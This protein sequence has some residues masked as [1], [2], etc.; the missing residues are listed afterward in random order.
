MG[1]LAE[2]L[3]L[4]G[5]VEPEAFRAVLD[6][7]HP[8]T[9]ERLARARSGCRSRR[10]GSSNQ[11]GLFDD[12]ALDTARTASRLRLTV[13][14]VRQL[15]L[16]GQRLDR[17][18][19]SGNYVRGSRRTRPGQKGPAA[20]VFP[21]HEFARFEAEH[22]GTK[23]RPGYDLTLRPPKSVSILWALSTTEQRAAIRQAHGEA[24]DEVVTYVERHALVARRGKGERGRIEVDGMVAAAFD[25]RT[26]RAGDPLLH[27]HVVTA[28]LTHTIDDRW[29]AIDARGL[30]DHAK[31]AGF[32]YQAHLRHLLT[33][34][35]GVA[36]EPVRHGWAEVTGVPRSVI[37]A[38]SKRRDEIEAMV[39][40]SGY[41]SARAHQAA[42][43]ST[44]HAKEYGVAPDAL[45]A[46]WREEAA[47]LGFGAD[48][49]AACFTTTPSAS[50]DVPLDDLFDELAGPSGLTQQASTFNRRDVV[51]A[52]SERLGAAPASTIEEAVDRF[53]ASSLVQPLAPEA[54]GGELVW[55]RGGSRRRSDDLARY[56]T[57]EL[58]AVE[59][60]L[61]GWARDGFGTPVPGARH[62]VVDAVLAAHGELSDE[63]VAMVRAVCSSS[64]PAIQPVA[65]RPG[66]GKTY[67]TAAAVE[68]LT[69]CGVPVVGCSLSAVAAAELES[70]TRLE[71]L[72]GREAS[73]IARLRWDL[74]VRGLAPG[75]VVIVDE[76]SMVGSRDLAHLAEHVA[77]AG[78]AI[79]LIGD[80]DQHGP[81]DTGGAF[82][83]IVRA[84]GDSVVVL[85]ENNRQVDEIDRACIDDFRQGLVG[86]ALAR[87]DA[88]GRIVRS[89]TASASFDAMAADWYDTVKAG[90]RGPMIAG[91][92][93]VRAALNERARRRLLEDGTIS[94]RPL[95]AAEREFA[96]GDWVLARK[97]DSRLRS[98]GGGF[99][100]NGRGGT[101]IGLDH[102]QRS[103]TVRFDSEGVIT[104]PAEYLEAGSLEYGYARTTYGV[105]GATLDRTGYHV[106]DTSSFEEG[107][108][109]L[110]R[111]KSS[112]RIYLV[113]G[114]APGDDDAS[115]RAHDAAETGLDTVSRALEQRR[116]KELAHDAD[117]TAAVVWK[118]FAGWNLAQLGAE[119]ERLEGV[120]A[121]APADVSQALTAAGRRR[122]ALLAQ[123]RTLEA[124]PSSTGTRGP[125][126]LGRRRAGHDTGSGIRRQVETIDRSLGGLDVRIET[127]RAQW[128]QRRDFLDDHGDE[129]SR[130]GLVRSASTARELQVRT[131]ARVSPSPGADATQGPAPTDPVLRQA[132]LSRIE[133]LAV[134]E[135][136]PPLSVECASPDAC[137]AE[138]GR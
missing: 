71:A 20:W 55:C 103:A 8:V 5:T 23:A 2:Q 4:R 14:R 6:G 110:T 131:A 76:A 117:P 1:S 105:E 81:V 129:V 40:E 34:R 92:N 137:E 125:W 43:L 37:R 112:T 122:D 56:S 85:V 101:V 77:T 17:H 123:R 54:A 61:L 132:W 19:G 25:H 72:T 115:H 78:G 57:P 111:A 102:G 83:S 69:A 80:P 64:A 68:A 45:D 65:G 90:G 13:G 120:L 124:Q 11:P 44:R 99:V 21:R 121:A 52:L 58:L 67:A 51:E 38:F 87:Y 96:V 128:Q 46:R 73:T 9:G 109:A 79:K 86:S 75:T 113:D 62:D 29:Q 63:Q 49:V 33:E 28:N 114:T 135:D 22:R 60:R 104:L 12:D 97:N 89:P 7:R 41:T 118:N 48:D 107:Y 100:K 130:L 134:R 42:T 35:L 108:V 24:V 88:A 106:S 136:R 116:A 82:R 95:V 127:L 94:G 66:A 84:Q 39:A 50:V 59:D 119:R 47:E 93:R 16:A 138:L 15:A 133:E 91:P 126:A 36:W 10:S 31:A 30:Y 98:V 3:G 70:A 26:S 18:Q 32:L 27:T 74:R 53:I